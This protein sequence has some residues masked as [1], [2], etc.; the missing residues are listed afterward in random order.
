MVGNTPTTGTGGY[1]QV[2]QVTIWY[3]TREDVQ[4]SL[5]FKETARNFRVI[6]RSIGAAT[7]KIEGTLRRVFYP[8]VDVRYKDWPNWQHSYPWRLWLEADELVSV[9]SLT[10]GG[11]TIPP[12][13]YNL[14]PAN[15]GPPYTSIEMSLASAFA[16][17]AGTATWQRSVAISGVFGGCPIAEDPGGS[18]N[19]SVASTVVT[20]IDITD[21][22]AIGV[23]SLVRVD[24]ER[25]VVTGK[26]MI[27]TGQ[28]LQANLLANTAGVSVSVVD[29]T[30]FAVYETLL[31]DSERMLI[32]DIAGNSLFVKRAWDGSVLTTHTSGAAIYAGRQ[33][34][35]SR[36][37][38]G[39]TAAV[40]SGSAPVSVY[41]VPAL[42]R[43]LAIAEVVN[44]LTEVRAGYQR[45]GKSA[46]S[47][48]LIAESMGLERLRS[49][50]YSAFGR[51]SR[52]RAI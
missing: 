51:Q 46:G 31:V 43:Q 7:H 39:S 1:K 35:V 50:A 38:L 30:E 16:F 20:S 25:M 42:I 29:G 17:S 44:E 6:D 4:E 37:V 18:L 9:D 22:S 11:V 34:T 15:I 3:C 40:H 21:S 12:S 36:G 5:D 24:S 14:E 32:V 26:S 23:G 48:Q 45:Q 28:T 8:T 13:A 47:S 27:A 10:S 52:I 19:S 49:D 33:L 2:K 41:A